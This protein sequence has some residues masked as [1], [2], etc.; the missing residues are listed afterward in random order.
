ML[1]VPV[2]TCA[3]ELLFRVTLAPTLRVPR[4]S[5]SAPRNLPPLPLPVNT[6]I[7]APAALSSV[8]LVRL[9]VADWELIT[10]LDENRSELVNPMDTLCRLRLEEPT[11]SPR[12]LAPAC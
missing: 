5:S 12:N 2:S 10:R 9:S 3:A 8:P 11:P 6:L 4:L 7:W 1:I